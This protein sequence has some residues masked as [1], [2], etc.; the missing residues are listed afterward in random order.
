MKLY[1]KS[2]KTMDVSDIAAILGTIWVEKVD[3]TKNLDP[4]TVKILKADLKKMKPK[5]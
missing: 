4:A 5:K 2:G 3:L 1:L